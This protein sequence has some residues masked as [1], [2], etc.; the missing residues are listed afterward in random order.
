MQN[1]RK[2]RKRIRVVPGNGTYADITLHDKRYYLLEAVIK[3]S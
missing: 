2:T 3:K 1:Q